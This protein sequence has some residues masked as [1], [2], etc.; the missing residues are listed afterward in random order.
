MFK[1]IVLATDLSP[2]WDGVLACAGEFKALG[3]E[4]VILTYVVSVKFMAG[5]EGALAAEARPRLE[6]KR[7]QLEAQGLQVTVETPVGLPA[8]SLND[9]A[10]RYG[11]DLLVVGSHG[12]SLWREGVLGCFTCAV[13]HKARYPVLL[14]NV[15]LTKPGQPGSCQISRREV[16]RHVLLPTDFSAISSRALEYVERLAAK[17]LTQ[18]T[19]LNALDV[20]LHEAYP[21]E[22]RDWAEG[23]ARDLLKHWQQR[24]T[25]AGLPR[26]E[27]VYDPGHPLPAI[28]AI[29]KS[30]DISLIVMGTQGR[31]FIQ[32]IFLGSVAHN[33]CRLAP[34]PVLLIPPASR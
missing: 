22:Y 10:C 9:I 8:D 33:V 29:L 28:L 20:P 15:R 27:A 11:A 7:Q 13:L 34:C 32:E 5:M 30:Q 2:A 23:A 19:L 21:P 24:L 12:Q 3:C 31:G 17:G 1:T 18:V 4:Q 26:V 25:Q 14:L 16:L 6:A